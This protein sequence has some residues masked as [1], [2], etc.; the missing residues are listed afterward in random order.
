MSEAQ[1]ENL[2]EVNQSTNQG[3]TNSRC[4]GYITKLLQRSSSKISLLNETRRDHHTDIKSNEEQMP[5]SHGHPQLRGSLQ[6]LALRLANTQDIEKTST[7]LKSLDLVKVQPLYQAPLKD[8]QQN[9]VPLD[10][11]IVKTCAES[12]TCFSDKGSGR[13]FE[14]SSVISKSIER[15]SSFNLRKE[16]RSFD[17]A[18]H[19]EEFV[20]AE[21]VPAG[22]QRMKVRQADKKTKSVKLRK[23]RAEKPST[24]KP[25]QKTRADVRQCKGKVTNLEESHMYS[26]SDGS[27]NG[28]VSTHKSHQ[29]SKPIKSHKNFPELAHVPQDQSRK[30]QSSRKWPS[31]S[32]IQL[33]TTLNGPRSKETPAS[34][35]TGMMR[36]LSARP[37][38]GQWG[39]PPR[40]LRQS[41]S[42]SSYLSYLES[43]YPAAPNSGRYPPRCESEFSEYSAECASLFHS[44]IAASSDG[45]MSD[46]TTN[47]FGD[48]E[49]SQGSQTASD[50]DS[51]LSLD[52]EDLL[53]EEEDGEVGLVWAQ[54]AMGPTAAGFSM[55]QRQRSDSAACRI[56]A[57]RALKK[58]IRRFQPAS[59]K[60]MTLV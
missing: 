23:T 25:Q 27:R 4:A 52:E 11:A 34:R 58:K 57:S 55:Q 22:S 49:S 39:C 18:P 21:F 37:R 28:L 16:E 15:R 24:K 17:L 35:K 45:E 2:E 8:L 56:K 47:R 50:S 33:P 1:D 29:T 42:T 3:S 46:Y 54:A 41:L 44:T 9:Y 19:S 7:A 14:S 13:S 20:H 51:S 60:V 26:S 36:S 5:R 6:Q 12:D 32:E 48:S 53:E 43:R 30:K 59:L 10:D 38:S 40:S 31:A